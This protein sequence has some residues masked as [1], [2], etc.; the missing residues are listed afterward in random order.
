MVARVNTPSE[1][2]AVVMYSNFYV[3]SAP[4][5]L[6]RPQ[7]KAYTDKNHE[8]IMR[9]R[10]KIFPNFLGMRIFLSKLANNSPI[11]TK[12]LSFW[13]GWGEFSVFFSKFSYDF[14][15]CTVYTGR[16]VSHWMSLIRCDMNIIKQKSCSIH[17]SFLYW[18]KIK[19]CV[20]ILEIYFKTFTTFNLKINKKCSPV[21]HDSIYVCL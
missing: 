11:L 9:K 19:W 16:I 2:Y 8:K 7:D 12:I 18:G 15:Q 6:G 3:H 4:C 20:S 14:C 5:A 21:L 1:C 13:G 10:Q 17:K